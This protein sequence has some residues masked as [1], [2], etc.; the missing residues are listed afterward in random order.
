[1]IP[2]DP[3]SVKNE[4][5]HSTIGSNYSSSQAR[6]GLLGALSPKRNVSQGRGATRREHGH[7]HTSE[8]TLQGYLDSAF[9]V[10]FRISRPAIP[11]AIAGGKNGRISDNEVSSWRNAACHN[12]QSEYVSHRTEN[13]RKQVC[14]TDHVRISGRRLSDSDA[15]QSILK[16][17]MTDNCRVRVRTRVSG[18]AARGVSCLRTVVQAL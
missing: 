12:K 4:T 18:C 13:Q 14:I 5:I 8:F 10:A 17:G 7:G 16:G 2:H 11:R 3:I 1:M 6:A 15:R 9:S